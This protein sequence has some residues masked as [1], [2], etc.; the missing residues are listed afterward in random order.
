MSIVSVGEG[1]IHEALVVR[2]RFFEALIG[3]VGGGGLMAVRSHQ[4]LVDGVVDGVA[5]LTNIAFAEG[6]V[7]DVSV[8]AGGA[9]EARAA[10][11][12]RLVKFAFGTHVAAERFH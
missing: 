11:G 12:V 4:L 2:E 7:E 1:W 8:I 6:N 9:G 3:C 10:R 5:H